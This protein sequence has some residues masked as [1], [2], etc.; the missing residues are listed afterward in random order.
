MSEMCYPN[1]P[2]RLG[3]RAVHLEASAAYSPAGGGCVIDGRADPLK[4]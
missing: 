3:T 2:E 4:F 1:D